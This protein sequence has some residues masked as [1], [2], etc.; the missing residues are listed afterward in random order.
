MAA[1][2]KRCLCRALYN[3]MQDMAA[4]F[5][6]CGVQSGDVVALFAENS[7]RWI[8]ADQGIMLNAG[9]NAVRSGSASADELL[10]IARVSGAS[11]LVVQD[12]DVL[13]RLAPRLYELEGKIK[14]VLVLWGDDSPAMRTVVRAPIYTFTEVRPAYGCLSCHPCMCHLNMRTPNVQLHMLSTQREQAVASV[15]CRMHCQSC[16]ATLIQYQ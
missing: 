10:D 1:D 4:A 14:F 3:H 2:F 11:G 5:W 6:H 16:H 12:N 8:L 13:T 9:I 7:S 15:D